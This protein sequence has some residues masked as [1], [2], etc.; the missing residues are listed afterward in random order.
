[1]DLLL[2]ETAPMVFNRYIDNFNLI[3][4]SAAIFFMLDS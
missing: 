1:M 2:G 3:L 4:S